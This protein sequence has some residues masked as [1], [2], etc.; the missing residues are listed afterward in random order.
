MRINKKS[1]RYSIDK[2]HHGLFLKEARLRHGYR[3]TE[4]AAEIC[5]TSYL[6]KIESGSI[7]PQLEVFEKLV[8]K[9][10]ITFPLGERICPIDTFRKFLYQEDVDIIETCLDN[11][12]FH[13]YEVQMINFF[14][15]VL[16]DELSKAFTSKK[17]IDQFRH[18][19]NEKEDQFYL[20]F[21]GLYYFK[22][23]EW[24][25]GKKCFKHSL[26]LMYQMNEEDPYLYFK[27]AEY[28]FQLQK[29]CIGFSYLERATTEFR[30]MLEK[31][32]V[33]KCGVLWCK[34]SIKTGDI[35]DIEMRLEELK[36][37]INSC[38]G[39]VQWSS[40]FNILGMIY[41]HRGQS[42]QAE[43]Y[44]T[45]SIEQR[46]GKIDEDL[47]IDVI[48][49]QYRRQNND[50]LVELIEG[51]DLNYFKTR[52]KMLVDFYYFK[53][54][55]VT[56]EN[57]ESFLK[58]DAIPYA[59]KGLDHRSVSLFTKELTKYY[60]NR[61]SHKKVAEAYYKWEKFCD[62]VNLTSMI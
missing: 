2:H 62:E 46:D 51:L 24:E 55:D 10:S 11:N 19:L 9:L 30:K 12:C 4:V 37:I 27:L 48:E 61:L 8:E 6:S 23:F 44:Y 39:H 14:Q 26:D 47:I 16:N 57:F 3:L 20:I 38:K 40:L 21:S 5:D 43:E 18:H 31:E 7:F 42:L 15:S 34:E 36:K 1:I 49:F 41:E 29:T 45:K 58:K 59:I 35:S 33:F 13:H 60:R 56:S 32:W 52:N 50:Q 54:T 22:V 17:I 25:E 28:Y 53:V